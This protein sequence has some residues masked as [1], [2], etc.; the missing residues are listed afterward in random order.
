MADILL[1]IA[2]Y[3]I[4][5]SNTIYKG[6]Y[7]SVRIEPVSNFGNKHYD[8]DQDG[9]ITTNLTIINNTNTSII[10]KDIYLKI[11]KE[12]KEIL[13]E[14][15][16]SAT[17]AQNS[18]ESVSYVDFKNSNLKDYQLMSVSS[19]SAQRFDD[20]TYIAFGKSLIDYSNI[21]KKRCRL[22]E[23]GYIDIIVEYENFEYGLFLRRKKSKAKTRLII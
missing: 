17:N 15:V 21:I 8:I 20:L 9:S 6:K 5:L 2:T 13:I 11:K 1:K 12:R 22:K 23:E 3:L 16:L 19:N 4:N 7:D 14:K 10:I 18:I